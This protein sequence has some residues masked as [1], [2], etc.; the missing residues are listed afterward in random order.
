MIAQF[1]SFWKPVLTLDI[2]VWY[3]AETL[4]FRTFDFLRRN[5][6]GSLKLV[7]APFR[8]LGKNGCTLIVWE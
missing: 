5:L 3:V 8:S 4:A 2:N 7:I 1:A 6:N